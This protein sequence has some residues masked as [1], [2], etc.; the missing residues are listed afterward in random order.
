MTACS[1]RLRRYRGMRLW[2]R[3]DVNDVRAL[4]LEKVRKARIH[5]VDLESLRKRLGSPLVRVTHTDDLVFFVTCNIGDVHVCDFSA[6]YD[7]NPHRPP[8]LETSAR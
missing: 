3:Q 7:G 4:L 1:H 6:T 2:R 8:P 5:L